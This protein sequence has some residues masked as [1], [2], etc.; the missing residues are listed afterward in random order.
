MGDLFWA[1]HRGRRLRAAFCI[2]GGAAVIIII[3]YIGGKRLR[4]VTRCD[5][6]GLRE[7]GGRV[8]GRT[9]I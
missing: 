3:I 6:W 1:Q 4:E 7:R 2:F 5:T 8:D 9:V